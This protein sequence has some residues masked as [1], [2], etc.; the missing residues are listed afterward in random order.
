M[1]FGVG[2]WG[3]ILYPLLAVPA[4][5]ILTVPV[6]ITVLCSP[7][8]PWRFT[9]PEATAVASAGA[10]GVVVGLAVPDA[11][12]AP[13][14][15]QSI[16]THLTQ[17]TV[18][19]SGTLAWWSAVAA[20]GLMLVAFILTVVRVAGE[21]RVAAAHRPPFAPCPQQNPMYPPP[22]TPWPPG[23]QERR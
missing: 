3:V 9:G 14:S 21:R 18:G 10:A 4:V 15:T 12:D 23:H 16:L 22:G 2:G 8:R 19:T 6:V 1:F 13:N 7:N 5:L 20:A 17:M 11:G